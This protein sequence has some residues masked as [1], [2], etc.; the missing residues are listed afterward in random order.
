MRPRINRAVLGYILA[1]VAMLI[2]LLYL[3]FPGGAVTETIKAAARPL[4]GCF[5]PSIRPGPPF[6]RAS[7]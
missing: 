4:P 2:L 6:R 7:R 1:G 3:R 5:F